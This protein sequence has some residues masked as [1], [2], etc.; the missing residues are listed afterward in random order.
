VRWRISGALG[1]TYRHYAASRRRRALPIRPPAGY[2]HRGLASLD[3][4][5]CSGSHRAPRRH[6]MSRRRPG[7]SFVYQ[8]VRSCGRTT[9]CRRRALGRE[10]ARRARV[11]EVGTV[12]GTP[13]AVA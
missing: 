6:R 10:P 7:R 1:A 4:G 3:E 2:D 8:S 12:I 11:R 5:P 13:S 9:I